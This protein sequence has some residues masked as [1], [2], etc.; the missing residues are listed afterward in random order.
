MTALTAEQIV[1]L[2]DIDV[3]KEAARDTASR[4]KRIEEGKKLKVEYDKG[5]FTKTAAVKAIVDA[6][7]KMDAVQMNKLLGIT[8]KKRVSDRTQ[9]AP[10]GDKQLEAMQRQLEELKARLEA[11]EA[12]NQ[13]VPVI[14]TPDKQ[15]DILNQIRQEELANAATDIAT[16]TAQR[17][18]QAEEAVFSRM[19]LVYPDW[20]GISKQEHENDVSSSGLDLEGLDEREQKHC[21]KRN[22]TQD[23]VDKYRLQLWQSKVEGLDDELRKTVKDVIGS[24]WDSWEMIAKA[25]KE[26][27]KGS[28]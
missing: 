14:A 21:L 17:E 20:D 24:M 16:Y 12:L 19:R 10:Q 4:N 15:L 2:I 25:Y 26:A 1:N 27:M 9:E 8:A 18:Q 3:F 5:S 11:S 7:G 13:L 6:G 22:F 23:K 28:L